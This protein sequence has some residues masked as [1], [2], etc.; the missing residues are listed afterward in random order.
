MINSLVYI[1][2]SFLLLLGF[3]LLIIRKLKIKKLISYFE[4]AKEEFEKA[5]LEFSKF[6]DSENYF[7]FKKIKKWKEKY[8]HLFDKINGVNIKSLKGKS[9]I[10]KLINNFNNSFV[11]GEQIRK[12]FNMNFVSKE[13]SQYKLFFDNIENR[14]LDIQ[15]RTAIVKDDDF[16]LVIAGAGSGKTT[17]IVGKAEYICKRYNVDPSDILLIAF[18]N[19]AVDNMKDRI[20]I[21]GCDIKTFSKLGKDIIQEAE[22]LKPSVFNDTNNK[23]GKIL[24]E[25]ISSD[26][27]FKK[28]FVE[29]FINF[30]V[31][32][33]PQELFKSK[34][35]YYNYQKA[36]SK[37]TLN[38]EYVKSIDE[39]MIANFFFV[40]RINYNYER[41]YKYD[42][43]TP[44]FSQYRPDF[45][46]PDHNIY[47][48]HFGV[49]NDKFDVPR[50]FI[51]KDKNETYDMARN[52]YIEGI[53]WKRNL[54][55]ENQTKLIETYSYDMPE[56]LFVNLKQQ[57]ISIGV[58]FQPMTD[59][60]I[61]NYINSQEHLKFQYSKFIDLLCTVLNLIKSNNV[62]INDIRKKIDKIEEE[63]LKIRSIK[64]IDIFEILYEKYQN[65]LTDNYFIDFSDMIMKSTEYINNGQYSK[66][67]KYI[68]IDEFQDTSYGRY[69]LIKSLMDLNDECKLFCVGDDWQS[70]FRFSGSDIS[71]FT[72]FEKMFGTFEESK[73][74][75][76]YRF[77]TN[78]ITLSGKFIMKNPNQK[79]KELKSH[80]ELAEEPIEILESS[81]DNAN[82]ENLIKVLNKLSSI[83]NVHNKNIFILGRYNF[84]LNKI[85]KDSL[86]FEVRD[87]DNLIVK[88]I[89]EKNSKFKV[90]YKNH[91]NLN[92]EFLTVHKAKGLEAD[93]VIIVDCNS[94][95]YGF[96]SEITDDPILS[97]LLSDSE[98]FENS[99]ERRAFYVAL[100]RAKQKVFVLFDSRFK[101]KF[102][103]EVEI[104]FLRKPQEI[105]PRCESGLLKVIKTGRNRKGNY[106]MKGCSNFDVGC[107]YVKFENS[108]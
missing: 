2:F 30:L 19:K 58:V 17:T 61:L 76:T 98:S 42:T 9:E 56:K 6:T 89:N 59:A 107:N 35:E 21:K 43:R 25:S 95:V 101:S 72:Q 8:V 70:I 20:T 14:N 55:Q 90:V 7:N 88:K 71:I 15:Q 48:E 39:F 86:N 53:K 54:H 96:P 32:N 22:Q 106:T 36:N 77:H 37:K 87:K 60:E 41:P 65:F 92:I 83:N 80:T 12:Q 75:T 67:Y 1:G 100:T 108:K 38:G 91:K 46:L 64:F 16:N 10:F 27:N 18:T 45:F 13:L 69:L 52:R 74:E 51:N 50:F 11:N 63:T 94:G 103:K 81:N 34:K 49:T 23:V 40:N 102:V 62:G 44:E 97:L 28:L 66:K 99:E 29:Y 24:L 84:N 79:K 85:L 105:C 78:L 104:D 3:L 31:Y 4:S 5:Q 73:I 47:L 93:F 82:N 68:F 57:L 33:K 26:E